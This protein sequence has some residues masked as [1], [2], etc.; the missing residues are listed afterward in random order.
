MLDDY[1]IAFWGILTLTFTVLLQS[2]VAAQS[3]ARAPGAI[4][5]KIDAS[6]SHESFVFRSH[7]TFNNSL[8][9]MSVMLG[10]SFLAILVE[11][12]TFWTGALIWVMAISRIIH[13]LLY[14]VIAT[15]KNPSPRSF[16][17]VVALLSNIALLALCGYTLS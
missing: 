10:A 6:L 5:G 7:R 13:M 9:N 2:L 3:K 16:F 1:T 14:Y 17:Y 8:E 15:E 4:P 11:A 12:D